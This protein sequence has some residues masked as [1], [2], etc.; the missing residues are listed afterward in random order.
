MGS[1]VVLLGGAGVAQ[2][3]NNLSNGIAPSCSSPYWDNPGDS[4]Q[5]MQGINYYNNGF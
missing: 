2:T 4:A 1:E 5:I 3:M